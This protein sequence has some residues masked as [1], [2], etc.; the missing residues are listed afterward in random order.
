MT[1]MQLHNSVQ[2]FVYRVA[3][4]CDLFDRVATRNSLSFPMPSPMEAFYEW[5]DT[6]IVAEMDEAALM[7]RF[8]KEYTNMCSD[9][10]LPIE[11]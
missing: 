8:E 7:K 6:Y 5:S 4:E 9:M 3:K 11:S 1:H 2:D 10:G